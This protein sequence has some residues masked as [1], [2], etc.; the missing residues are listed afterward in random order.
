LDPLSIII[1]GGVLGG[2]CLLAVGAVQTVQHSKSPMEQRL[3]D[4]KKRTPVERELDPQT[5]GAQM[6]LAE[7]EESQHAPRK[8]DLL[9]LVSTML[10]RNAIVAKLEADLRQA[11]SNWR[12]SELVYF[13]VV[14][15]LM[16][17]VVLS[18]LIKQVVV[19]LLVS[20][21]VLLLP[22]LYVRRVKAKYL[23]AFANQLA[24]TL[25]LQSN[26]LRSGYSFMQSLD[27]VAREA[28]PPMSDEFK[29]IS[30][31]I[32]VGKTVEQAMDAFYQRIGSTDVNLVV[33]AVLIQ[34]EV[35]G[36]LAEILDTISAVIR[37][38]VQIQG[39]I[40]TLTTQGR[41]S[42]FFLALMPVGLGFTIHFVTKLLSGGV[43]DPY[44]KPLFAEKVGHYM[45]GVGL[46]MQLIGFLVIRKIVSIEV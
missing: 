8:A 10:S 19:A 9:P 25:V 7:R 12:A 42:G 35:G 39:E 18:L 20:A 15:S 40:R 16:A 36:A 27:M 46:V 24:D 11:R 32:Q 14:L 2:V 6:S 5:K 43:G 44:M 34:R 17:F 33:M 13:S 45:I 38:R 1:F 29:R 30:D 21:L 26:A 3:N 22:F 37:E 23:N 28:E 31:E 41:M 4:I